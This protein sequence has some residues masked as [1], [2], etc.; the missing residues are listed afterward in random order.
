[1]D[2]LKSI[3]I[4]VNRRTSSGKA[5]RAGHPPPL[6]AEHRVGGMVGARRKAPSPRAAHAT[7]AYHIGQRLLLRGGGNDWARAASTCEVVAALPHEGGPFLY[8]VRSEL[9][10]FERVVAEADLSPMK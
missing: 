9:E 3:A 1:M 8:R 6:G 2:P 7:H 5:K 10:Q 4:P